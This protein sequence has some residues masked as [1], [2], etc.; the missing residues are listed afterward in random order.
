MNWAEYVD[1]MEARYDRWQAQGRIKTTSKVIPVGQALAAQPWVM[2]TEQALLALRNARSF[3][4]TDCQCRSLGG[5]CGRPA[6]VCFLLNDKADRL[7]EKGLARRISLEEAKN[8][9]ALAN[10]HG[11]VPLTLFDPKQHLMALCHCCPCCCHDLQLLL[12]RGR[13]ELVARS[14]YWA[15]QDMEACTHCGACVERCYFGARVWVGDLVVYDPA[16][17]YG[18]GLCVTTCPAWAIALELRQNLVR[19]ERA[20]APE[21]V[22]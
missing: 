14:E 20:S 1:S 5:H 6:E 22:G 16:K 19:P 10:E 3:A 18:C 11:L 4:V 12:V 17:C 13:D 9:L 7:V 2:P 21:R 8:R 15:V